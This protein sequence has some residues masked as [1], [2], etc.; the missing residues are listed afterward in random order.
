MEKILDE[1]FHFHYCLVNIDLKKLMTDPPWNWHSTWKWMVGILISFWDGLFSGA[2]L[3]LGR[4]WKD[5]FIRS[6]LVVNSFFQIN[7]PRYNFSSVQT[8]MKS[9]CMFA[10]FLLLPNF[11]YLFPPS[12]AHSFFLQK[13][14]IK[15][16]LLWIVHL[17]HHPMT[18]LS[19]ILMVQWK[20][21]GCLKGNDPIGDTPI[22][23]WT[24]IMV[25][26]GSKRWIGPWLARWW[27]YFF[28]FH[29]YLGKW[30]NLTNIFHRGWNHQLVSFWQGLVI[31]WF[32]FPGPGMQ[33]REGPN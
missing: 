4:V 15:L 17:E 3:V 2:I 7:Q 25:F 13:S 31:K 27:F 20:M 1:T 33:L 21:V 24:M 14:V 8:M 30:S 19:P 32:G 26:Q 18:T 10:V 23:H 22:F 12:M 16:L 6:G 5:L 11:L 9:C 28:Y 29:P